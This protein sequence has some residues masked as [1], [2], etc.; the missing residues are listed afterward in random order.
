[1]NSIR[2]SNILLAGVALLLSPWVMKAQS[3]ETF[4][5]WNQPIA[6]F[7]IIGNVY[8]IGASDVTS[9]LITTPAGHI[10]IDGGFVET[11]PLIEKNIRDLGFKLEDVKVLLSS[12]AHF[13][14][15]GGLA[16][17]KRLTG[18]R[19]IA[20]E[21]EAQ[22]LAR[23]GK[24]DFHYGDWGAFPPVTADQTV[25]DGEKVELG[26]VTLTAHLTPG[27]TKGNTTW[28]MKT[29]EGDRSY[30][31]VVMGSL[32]APGYKLV[33][34]TNYPNIVADYTHSFAVL[35]KL[36]CD[37]FLSQHGFNFSLKEKMAGKDGKENPFIDPAG[38]RKAIEQADRSL[39][40]QLKRESLNR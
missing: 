1:M 34:N 37:V 31:V 30:D 26:G 13:D 7:H 22:Q 2:I 10:V 18:A 5:S 40:K 6:P 3:T 21:P 28:T 4:R 11:A 29:S 17:L 15:A 24:G 19:L 35:K 8:Y 38:Y 36:P 25:K 33:N 39:E 9:F 12:H 14:H 32:S 23:G 20:S 16:E 27:H